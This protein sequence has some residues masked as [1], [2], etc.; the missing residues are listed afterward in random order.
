MKKILLPLVL[1]M[2]SSAYAQNTS[3]IKVNAKII[4]GCKLSGDDANFGDVINK[5]IYTDMD[6]RIQCSKTTPLTLTVTSAVNPTSV[7]A[8]FMTIGKKKISNPILNSPDAI[9]YLIK[10]NNVISNM[11]YTVT[12]RP[13]SEALIINSGIGYDYSMKLT[14]NTSEEVTLP[15]RGLI[16]NDNDF[17]KLIPGN[18]GDD[19]TY[20]IVF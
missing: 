1:V 8:N 7:N 5:N 15:L 11:K 20:H 9:H 4:S 18:Y 17:M 16:T 2:G 10:T 14:I 12:H 6:L 3:N 13:K 19:A